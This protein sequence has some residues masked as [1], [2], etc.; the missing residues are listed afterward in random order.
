MPAVSLTLRQTTV[1]SSSAGSA[2][3]SVTSAVTASVGISPAVF[4]YR[5]D[6]GKFSHYATPA[7]MDAYPDTQ[8]AAV[9]D[10][11]DFYRQA[12]LTRVWPTISG[13]NDDLTTTRVRLSALVRETSKIQGSIVVDQV[14]EITAG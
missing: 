10:G 14:I 1:P 12:S 6:N 11:K 9:A 7:D 8:V 3:Y 13:M 5:A 2:S 4:V